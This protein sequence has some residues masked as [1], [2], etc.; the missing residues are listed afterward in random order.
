[1]Q[2]LC[3]TTHIFVIQHNRLY[4][5]WGL[6]LD[7]LCAFRTPMTAPTIHANMKQK[8]WVAYCKQRLSADS[9]CYRGSVVFVFKQPNIITRGYR[10]VYFLWSGVSGSRQVV[11]RPHIYHFFTLCR[12]QW[13]PLE[14]KPFS[15]FGLRAQALI[16]AKHRKRITG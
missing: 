1:M 7:E 8:H 9:H 6:R 10:R 16:G 11:G 3:W 5:V 15:R 13:K 12:H 4:A 2:R 14:I